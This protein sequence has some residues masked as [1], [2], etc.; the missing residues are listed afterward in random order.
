[1]AVVKQCPRRLGTLATLGRQ[2]PNQPVRVFCPDESRLGLHLP[3]RRRL[4]DCGIKPIQVVEPLY[5][6]YWLYAAV[7]PTTGDT[8]GWEL[9][10]LDAACFT[11]F[12]DK[13]A[14]CYAESLH[15]V[16]LDQAPAHV[17]QRGQWPENVVL[18]W[19]P[20]YRPELTPV[21]RLWEDLKSRLDVVDARVRSSLTALQEH[22][23]D[24]V[25]RYTAETIASLTG[26][27]YLVEAVH[28]LSL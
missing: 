26:Y 28:A 9:P 1:V 15:I 7:E 20:A 23:A 3:V 4:T 12:L 17:A 10:R 13:F 14:Q 2:A 27:T 16:L 22:G 19:L 5:E 8:F 21:E 25:R 11:F 24:L 6:S 18:V